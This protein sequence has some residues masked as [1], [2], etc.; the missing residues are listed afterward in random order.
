M[1]INLK[2]MGLRDLL[3]MRLF[4]LVFL[5]VNIVALLFIPITPDEI[6]RQALA[7]EWVE[8][9]RYDFSWPPMLMLINAFIKLLGGGAYMTRALFLVIELYFFWR[10]YEKSLFPT[11]FLAVFIFPY[12]ALVL[13]TASPQ[14]LM[15][16][17][18]PLLVYAI[19]RH[20]FLEIYFIS[21]SLYLINPTCILVLLGSALVVGIFDRK[22]GWTYLGAALLALISTLVVAYVVLLN[23]GSFM[24]TLTNNGPLNLFLGNNPDPMSYRGVAEGAEWMSYSSA[25][26]LTNVL[27]YL[28]EEPYLFVQNYFFK[29]IF[30][31]A[32]FDHFRSGIGASFQYILFGYV[33]LVQLMCYFLF[34]KKSRSDKSVELNIAVWISIMAWLLYSVFF[35]KLRFRIPFDV[36]IFMAAYYTNKPVA[37]TVN[38][39]SL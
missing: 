34:F 16:V 29:L 19:R 17:L 9:G 14:G 1:M 30:W 28:F 2:L 35:V 7:A 5:F 39:K 13:S 22:V 23:V 18:L 11:S 27:N 37:L 8:T 24:P 31:F 10:L 3:T 32:P 26:Y 20:R 12:L 38:Q 36:L 25:Q 21:L 6:S 15:V 33:A 4:V